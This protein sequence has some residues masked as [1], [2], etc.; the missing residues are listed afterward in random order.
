MVLQI[1]IVVPTVRIG[2]VGLLV[3]SFSLILNLGV[4]PAGVFNLWIFDY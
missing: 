2:S 1:K 4:R 3:T